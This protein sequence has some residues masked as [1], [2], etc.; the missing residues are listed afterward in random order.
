MLFQLAMA[1]I[2]GR[3]LK[4]ILIELIEQKFVGS[5]FLTHFCY[6]NKSA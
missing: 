1:S 5:N 6:A 2:H 3:H 4:F